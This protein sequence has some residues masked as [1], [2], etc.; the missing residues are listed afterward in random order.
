LCNDQKS[1]TAIK[2]MYFVGADNVGYIS[3]TTTLRLG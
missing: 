3:E 2:I 1:A